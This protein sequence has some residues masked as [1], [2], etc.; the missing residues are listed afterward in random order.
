M[1]DLPERLDRSNSLTPMQQGR[2]RR[3]TSQAELELYRK[4]LDA[5]VQTRSDQLDSQA[6]GDAIQTAM[7]EE[8]NVLD[9]GLARA[10]GSAAKTEIVAQKVAMFSAVNNKRIGRRFS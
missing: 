10:A 5:T 2:A 1:S 8:M 3:M 4:T 9:Y 6:L 7:D